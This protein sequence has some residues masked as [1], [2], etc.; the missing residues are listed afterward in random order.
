MVLGKLSVPGC[1]T[2]LDRVLTRILKIGVPNTFLG[3]STCR[4]P[5]M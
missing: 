5:T 1:S 2:K 4:S 3:K